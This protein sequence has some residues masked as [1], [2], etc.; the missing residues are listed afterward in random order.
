MRTPPPIVL[1]LAARAGVGIAR[2]RVVRSR[3][4]RW[5]AGMPLITMAL[6]AAMLVVPRG[7]RAGR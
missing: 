1:R 4:L 3:S 7:G 6:V 5:A 2:R